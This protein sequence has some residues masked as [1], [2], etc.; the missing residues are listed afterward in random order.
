MGNVQAVELLVWGCHIVMCVCVP[1]CECVGVCVFV[2]V[3]ESC[4]RAR[5]WGAARLFK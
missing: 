1:E 5:A 3:L 4:S 2:W